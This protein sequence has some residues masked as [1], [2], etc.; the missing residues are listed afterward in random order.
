LSGHPAG[1]LGRPRRLVSWAKYA[2]KATQSAGRISR[3]TSGK[4]NPWIA[5]TLGEA[6]IGTAGA[7]LNECLRLAGR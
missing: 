2:P 1:G 7:A 5:S 6:C 4:G 3:G